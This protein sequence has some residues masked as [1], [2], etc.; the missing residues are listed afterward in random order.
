MIRSAIRSSVTELAMQGLQ[1]VAMRYIT[2]NPWCRMHTISKGAFGMIDHK[3]MLASVVVRQLVI[4][5]R[6]FKIQPYKNDK[7][8]N[9]IF[10]KNG[11]RERYK[12]FVYVSAE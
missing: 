3:Q 11:Y 4:K 10:D 9:P 8:G 1:R 2:D 12:H 7:N 6:V 5:G